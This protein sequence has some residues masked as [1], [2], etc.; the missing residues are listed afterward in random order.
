MRFYWLNNMKST[1]RRLPV[2]GNLARR[3]HWLLISRKKLQEP[4]SNSAEYWERRY[5]SGNSS[6]DGS[7]GKLARFKADVLNEF[8]AQHQVSSVIEFG[9]GDGSQLRFARYPAYAG[10][11]VSET[12]VALCRQ[13]YATDP[14]KTFHLMQE[15]DG[16]KAD[17]S[18]SLD[19]IYH[20]TEDDTFE[21]YM[22][23][24]FGAA[25]RYVI[26]YSS[27]TDER[28]AE[29]LKHVRHRRFTTWVERHLP[30][31]KLIQHVP[32]KYPLREGLGSHADFYIY[33]KS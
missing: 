22:R 25:E 1:V 13:V 30:E 16:V 12:A 33:A 7:Y 17:L 18:L 15:Y 9:C 4:F 29:Q 14:T 2:I 31:W 26:V 28:S 21:S 10:Y 24:L 32:N 19:V 8:V 23:T 11:D 5:A 3:V 20:L 27:N 6:G